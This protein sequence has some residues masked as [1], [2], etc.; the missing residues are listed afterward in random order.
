MA[1][2]KIKYLLLFIITCGIACKHHYEFPG[3]DESNFPKEVG[4]IL[5]G[6]CAVSGCHN[7][8]SY[9]AAANLNLTS[10][11]KMFEGA[12][13]GS[14]TIPFRADFSPLCYFTNTDSSSGIAL[15]PTMPI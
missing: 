3:L 15:E 11:D 9:S 14:V 8:L 13:S 12:S 4:V 7:D 5:L 2:L 1:R 6:K 10:W